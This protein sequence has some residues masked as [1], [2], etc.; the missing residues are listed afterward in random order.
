MTTRR[1]FTLVETLVVIAVIALLAALLLPALSKAKQSGRRTA[2]ASNLRQ[3]SVALSIY[4][5]E[6]E[7]DYPPISTTNRWPSHLYRGYENFAVLLC[8]ADQLPPPGNFGLRPDEAPRSYVMN[9]FRDHFSTT[10]SAT[11][12]QRFNSGTLSGTINEGSIGLPADTVVFGEKKTRSHDFYFDLAGVL[13]GDVRSALEQR[14]HMRTSRE[15]S[16]GSNYVFVDGS[17]K[18]LARGR[19][20]HPVNLWGVTGY[21]RTNDGSLPEVP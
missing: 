2:C 14:R 1:A 6:N 19:S 4:A 3:L 13:S 20:L 9:L 8:P 5:G 12:L 15:D 21:F 17:V 11:E 16:G 10:L 18:Y 7:G